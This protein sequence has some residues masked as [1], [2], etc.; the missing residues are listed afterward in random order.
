MIF[1]E[2]NRCLNEWPGF[3]FEKNISLAVWHHY[4]I[5]SH[6][7]KLLHVSV[8]HVLWLHEISITDTRLCKSVFRRGFCVPKIMGPTFFQQ[9]LPLI[10][11]HYH[12]P[13]ILRVGTACIRFLTWVLNQFLDDVFYLK[14]ENPY[15]GHLL[16]CVLFSDSVIACY[17]AFLPCGSWASFLSDSE[18]SFQQ[19]DSDSFLLGFQRP[20]CC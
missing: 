8:P 9:M 10:L 13:N 5:I 2:S 16:G 14:K 3:L 18:N 19:Q 4:K 17:I 1:K 7:K 20:F 11:Q 15:S 6:W 12:N